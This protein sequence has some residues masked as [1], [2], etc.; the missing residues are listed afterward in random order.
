MIKLEELTNPDSC[1]NRAKDHEMTFVLLARDVVAPRVIRLWVQE[2]LLSGKNQPHD[3][4][5]VDALHC[6]DYM[7]QQRRDGIGL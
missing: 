5:I 1:M 2:R 4:Q 7:E 3:V 6:A